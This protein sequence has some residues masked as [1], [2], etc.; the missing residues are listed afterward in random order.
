MKKLMLISVLV[1]CVFANFFSCNQEPL[2][3]SPKIAGEWAR[4][5][6]GLLIQIHPDSTAH[7][8]SDGILYLRKSDTVFQLNYN[9]GYPGA[10]LWA[11]M[12]LTLRDYRVSQN[13][14]YPYDT[15]YIKHRL[16]TVL[17]QTL[18]RSN[19]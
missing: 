13:E 6:D 10:P 15:I 11:N 1:F 17:N 3:P 8:I 2:K 16:T 9:S 4:T 5:R 7:I 19:L 14:E 18:V 12:Y